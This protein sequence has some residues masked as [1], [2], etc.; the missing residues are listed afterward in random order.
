MPETKNIKQDLEILKQAQVLDRQI[1]DLSQELFH[2]PVELGDSEVEFEKS[3]KEAAVLEERLKQIKLKQ[4]EKELDLAQKEENIN[5]RQ[6]QMNQVKTNEEYTAIRLEIA[7]MKADNSVLEEAILLLMD[8]A[9][10][11]AKNLNTNKETLKVEEQKL[12]RRKAELKEREKSCQQQIEELK[13]HKKE[14]ILQVNPEISRFYERILAKK[15]GMAMARVDGENCSS[16]QMKL[17]PQL[18]N[19]VKL[20]ESIVV[21]ENCTRILYEE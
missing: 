8:E 20:Q 17:R 5:K 2:I 21:C 19:E 9:D 16:C 18:L 1:Y 3:R 10:L 13:A 6:A 15:N 11:A 12:D 7:S 14:L 4:K